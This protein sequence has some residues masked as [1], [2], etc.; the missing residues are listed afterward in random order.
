MD[1]PNL[2]KFSSWS[3]WDSFHRIYERFNEEAHTLILWPLDAAITHLTEEAKAEDEK[4]EPRLSSVTGEERE[5]LGE[6]QERNWQYVPDQER[7]LRNMALVGLLS[8]LIYT[9]RD[10][11][12]QSELIA[13]RRGRY[14]GSGELAQLWEEFRV[15]FGLDFSPYDQHIAFLDRLRLVRNQIVH[16]G[17][18]ANTPKPL[19]QCS[20][21]PD[22][23][24][25]MYDTAFSDRFPEFVEGSSFSAQ[26]VVKQE[27][28][29]QG[30]E[31]SIE[32]V[33]W[34]SEQLRAKEIESER[35]S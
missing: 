7:F 35:Q 4:L 25:D 9:L 32:I 31:Y 30:I 2:E 10:M 3:D 15:R 23:T 21:K 27:H 34:I 22:G 19:A 14:E 18:E 17:G 6:Q 33:R 24:F 12:R 13:P 29:D 11:S 16:D 8:R 1:S 20:I 5:W 26:V 28:L